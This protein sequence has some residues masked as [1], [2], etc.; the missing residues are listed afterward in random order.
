MVNNY[1][2]VVQFQYVIFAL[3]NQA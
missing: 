2:L 3:L 1:L